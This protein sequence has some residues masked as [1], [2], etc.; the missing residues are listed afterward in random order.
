MATTQPL[1]DYIQYYDTLL[2]RVRPGDT[3]PDIFRRY[4]PSITEKRLTLLSE[5]VVA[6]SPLLTTPDHLRP[7][8]LIALKIP[9]QYCAVPTP[10][11]HLFT[12]RTDNHNWLPELERDWDNSAREDRNLIATLLPAF[13]GMGSTQMSMIDTTFST[14][15]PLMREMVI[16]YEDYKNEIFVETAGGVAGGLLYTTGASVAILLVSTPVGWVAGLAIGLGAAVTGYLLGKAAV[17][18]YDRSGARVDFV[19]SSGAGILCSANSVRRMPTL[20]PATL[21]VL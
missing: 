15:T 9:Q 19:N 11:H 7:D 4:H 21:S 13:I 6:E 20:S 17:K 1:G 12:V 18:I 8:Q 3:L 2:Y 10:D 5:R 16:N 14:N